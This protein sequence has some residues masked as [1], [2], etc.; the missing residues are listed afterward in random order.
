MWK[1]SV[2]SRRT[3][4]RLLLTCVATV[5]LY[6]SETWSLGHAL[7]RRLHNTWMSC[8][9]RALGVRQPVMT[10]DR[11][12]N[13]DMLRRIGL[14]SIHTLLAQRMGRWLGHG[15]RMEPTRLPHGFLFGTLAHRIFPSAVVAGSAG[16]HFRGRVHGTLN[17]LGLGSTWARRA[18]D[19]QAWE[20]LVRGLQLPPLGRHANDRSTAASVR[21]APQP[22]PNDCRCTLRPFVG[23]NKQGLSRHINNKHPVSKPAWSCTDCSREFRSKTTLTKHKCEARPAAPAAAVRNFSCSFPNCIDT[24]LSISQ[25]NRHEREQCLARP[26]SGA[27]RQADGRLALF[28]PCGVATPFYSTRALAIHRTRNS[29]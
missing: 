6:G 15:A 19:R 10:N 18:Q 24:F 12:T 27:V 29:H 1:T 16:I 13:A 9:R 4:A 23:K 17:A 14:P 11:L 21:A 25:K 20:H 3:K 2:V 26:G 28:C 22:L 5:L 8:V 7:S